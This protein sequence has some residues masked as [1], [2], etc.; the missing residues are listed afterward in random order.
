MAKTTNQIIKTV[1][2]TVL[3]DDCDLSLTIDNNVPKYYKTKS[4]LKRAF[5]NAVEKVYNNIKDKEI[6]KKINKKRTKP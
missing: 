2:S 5:E 4:S 3:M 1:I 6:S